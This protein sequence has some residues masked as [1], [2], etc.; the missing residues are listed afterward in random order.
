MKVFLHHGEEVLVWEYNGRH[1]GSR[2]TKK[3]WIFP[4]YLVVWGVEETEMGKTFLRVE[5]ISVKVKRRREDPEN[6]K[7]WRSLFTMGQGLQK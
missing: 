3:M 5:W 2:A 4:P 7:K 6:M 1:G